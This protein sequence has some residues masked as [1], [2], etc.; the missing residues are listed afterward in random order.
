MP[1]SL[2]GVTTGALQFVALLW[3]Q[4]KIFYTTVA[5]FEKEW[6]CW[7]HVRISQEGFPAENQPRV[8]AFGVLIEFLHAII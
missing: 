7:R 1:V 6:T 8:Q 4:V 2:S 3:S 5:I